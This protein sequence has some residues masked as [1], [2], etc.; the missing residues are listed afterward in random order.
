MLK[1]LFASL[2]AKLE[3]S[4]VGKTHTKFQNYNEN[5]AEQYWIFIYY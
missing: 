3:D 1:G 5:N 2:N 4:Q